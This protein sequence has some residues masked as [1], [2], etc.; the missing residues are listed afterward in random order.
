MFTPTRLPPEIAPQYHEEGIYGLLS[1]GETGKAAYDAVV[2]RLAQRIARAY[3]THW[4]QAQVPTDV[5]QLRT[6][7]EEGGHDRGLTPPPRG[8]SAGRPTSS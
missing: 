2:W 7:F 1:L 4:V 6:T 8:A 3:R 5:R